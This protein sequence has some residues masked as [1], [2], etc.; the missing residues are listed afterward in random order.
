M[1]TLYAISFL[2]YIL[3][4][5]VDWFHVYFILSGDT[6]S[7]PL[8]PWF[9]IMIVFIAVI[10]SMIN[11]LL[12]V[13]DISK[14][15]VKTTIQ[16]YSFSFLQALCMEN[17]FVQRLNV[18]PYRNGFAVICEAFVEWL[19]SFNNF[20][21]TFL[22]MILRDLPWTLINYFIIT[23]CRWPELAWHYTLFFSSFSI[24]TS[25]C[26]RSVMLY[27]SYRRLIFGDKHPRKSSTPVKPLPG[28]FES[29]KIAVDIR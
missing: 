7:F 22:V 12:M 26:W 10:G 19:Q 11:L 27:Y 15:T 13:H 25:L 5:I 24:I 4:S 14:K 28:I 8:I 17:A 1:H 18:A 21:V 23:S 3:N 9:S 16:I 2:I 6:V 20:R 29:L